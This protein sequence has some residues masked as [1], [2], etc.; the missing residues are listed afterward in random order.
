MNVMYDDL[1]LANQKQLNRKLETTIDKR[2]REK[3]KEKE[4]NEEE[5]LERYKYF[6][7]KICEIKLVSNDIFEKYIDSEALIDLKNSNE[8][9][10]VMKKYISNLEQDELKSLLE[11]IDDY[12]F[13]EEIEKVIKS[14]TLKNLENFVEEYKVIKKSKTLEIIKNI[15]SDFE[16]NFDK[17]NFHIDDFGKKVIEAAEN[18]NFEEKHVKDI[19]QLVKK[20]MKQKFI[21]LINIELKYF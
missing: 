3:L 13:E 20:I 15:K 10:K 11:N 21:E 16:D 2:E 4:N 9:V 14:E 7:D 19:K 18:F 8:I 1:Y 12:E 17:L 5:I 6:S